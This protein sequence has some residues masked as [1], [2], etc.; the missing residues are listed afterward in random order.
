MVV[1]HRSYERLSVLGEVLRAKSWMPVFIASDL[2]R[3]PARQ[4]ASF[5]WHEVRSG[6]PS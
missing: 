6:I 2:S 3:R 4:R 1:R 5:A